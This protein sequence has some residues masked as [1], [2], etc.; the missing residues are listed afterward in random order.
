MQIA[1][2][3]CKRR[4]SSEPRIRHERRRPCPLPGRTAP[5]CCRRRVQRLV[6][7]LRLRWSAPCNVDERREPEHASG[8]A[9]RPGADQVQHARGPAGHAAPSLGAAAGRRLALH[10]IS[11][12]QAR[13]REP[14]DPVGLLDRS[15]SHTD[16]A[17][18]GAAI[19]GSSSS[20]NRILLRKVGSRVISR[21]SRGRN[22]A[23][24]KSMGLVT[25]GARRP[26]SCP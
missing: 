14:L 20:Q 11:F 10:P 8:R 23:R 3:V 18:R 21:C 13:R 5:G 16:A 9:A 1:A 6:P 4:T 24:R 22:K 7:R 19:R 17:R 25:S 26:G 2:P 15:R 12:T